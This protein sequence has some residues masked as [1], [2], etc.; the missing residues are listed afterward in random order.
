MKKVIKLLVILSFLASCGGAA[1]SEGDGIDSSEDVN[2]S[3]GTF[4]ISEGTTGIQE[5]D[6]DLYQSSCSLGGMWSPIKIYVNYY[7]ETVTI[8]DIEGETVISGTY[9]SVNEEFN[10][11]LTFTNAEN[12]DETMNCVGA[13][14]TGAMY[15][16]FY[17]SSCSSEY[18][19]HVEHSFTSCRTVSRSEATL[20][21]LL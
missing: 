10:V 1:T 3:L 6:E 16:G 5:L 14:E 15:N 7:Q 12:A 2:T 21:S 19:R 4:T 9:D 8:K 13:I 20:V 18:S 17:K 11:S